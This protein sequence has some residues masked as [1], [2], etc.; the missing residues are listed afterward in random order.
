MADIGLKARAVRAHALTQLALVKILFKNMNLTNKK[1]STIKE[2]MEN[3]ELNPMEK[4][5][6]E[7]NEYVKSNAQNWKMKY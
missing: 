3:L 5:L 6:I 1:L 7:N 4:S 2:V